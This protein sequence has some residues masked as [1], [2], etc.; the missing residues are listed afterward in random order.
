MKHCKQLIA[1][2][3]W[4]LA[5]AAASAQGYPNRPVHLI[6]GFAPGGAADTVGRA[7]SDAFGRALG[8][9]VIIDN[10][11]GAGSSLAAEFVAK[12]PAD[13]Y[14]VLIAS[15]S[16]ISVN[17]ALKPKLGYKASDLMPVGKLT[18]SPLVVAVNPGTGINSM[19]ELI[20]AAKKNPKGLNYATSG[21]G[22]APHLGASLFSLVAN[23]EMTHIPY[24]GGGP[25]V[26]S[27][28]AGDTQVTFGTPPSVLSLVQAGR[29][30][31]LGVTTLE[32]TPL[33]PDLPGMREAGVPD[34]VIDFWYG[35]FVPA[36]TPPEVVKKLF[37]AANNAMQQPAVKAA[38]AKEGTEV[39]VSGSPQQF[40]AFLDANAKFW[41]KL[42]KDA[43]VTID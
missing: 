32:R 17:P 1:A 41:V 5:C 43:G 11:P 40:A 19:K 2:G 6:V 34:F 22:S 3:V 25:A 23:V 21:N 10:K 20:A 7:M 13:G 16:N 28:V 24:K 35:L 33:F 38:L 36:G 4:A 30:R 15:P 9:T 8:Q 26:Q 39:S 31:G 37:D 12:S 42:V 14:N 27:L 18:S 29:L